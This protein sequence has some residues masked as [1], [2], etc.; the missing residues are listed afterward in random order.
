MALRLV[1]R[2]RR[3]RRRSETPRGARVVTRQK[4]A[5]RPEDAAAVLIYI[6]TRVM[7]FVASPGG[8]MSASARAR[9]NPS[10]F[11]RSPRAV[12]SL[13]PSLRK[14]TARIKTRRLGGRSPSTS[15][16]M[17][18]SASLGNMASPNATAGV[19]TPPDLPSSAPPSRVP[20]ASNTPTSASTRL[21]S[22]CPGSRPAGHPRPHAFAVRALGSKAHLPEPRLAEPLRRALAGFGSAAFIRRRVSSSAA[23]R[24]AASMRDAVIFALAHPT[25]VPSSNAASLPS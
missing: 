24:T 6:E 9:T 12:P 25:G 7:S 13:R 4:P 17:P 11:V 5:P 20:S 18:C 16:V 22:P 8:R 23:P 14:Q 3:R 21:V 15:Y 1:Q 10:S 2:R 19:S